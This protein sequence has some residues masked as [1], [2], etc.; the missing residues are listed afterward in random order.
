MSILESVSHRA[1]PYP[2]GRATA[3]I[4]RV[5]C[6]LCHCSIGYAKASAISPTVY[7]MV[8]HECVRS[9]RYRREG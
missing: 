4:T 6:D 8:C 3:P 1:D 5:F 2:E 7:R 9:G